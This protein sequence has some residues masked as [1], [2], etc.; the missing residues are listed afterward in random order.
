MVIACA[1]LADSLN[2]LAHGAAMGTAAMCGE[3]GAMQIAAPHLP[4][5][6]TATSRTIQHRWMLVPGSGSRWRGADAHRGLVEPSSALALEAEGQSATGGQLSARSSQL[7]D[8]YVFFDEKGELAPSPD[9]PATPACVD[10]GATISG[11]SA[12]DVSGDDIDYTLK[13][14][15]LTPDL[16]MTR[17]GLTFSGGYS[18]VE[19]ASV[20]AK[21]ARKNIGGRDREVAASIRLSQLRQAVEIGYGD[22]NFLGS[23]LALAPTLF[24]NRMSAKGFASGLGST[25]FAQGSYGATIQLSRKFE[26]Q[27]T[28]NAGYRLSAD[29]FRMRGKNRNCD[30]AL[31]GSPLCSALGNTTTSQ[32]SVSLVLDRRNRERYGTRGFRLRLAQ[33]AG[34]GGTAPFSRTRIGGEAHLGLGERLTLLV[35]VEG[36]YLAPMG[37]RDIPLFDR[38][39]AGDTSLRGFDLRG[40]GPKVRPAG[41]TAAQNIALGGRAYYAAR[42][43]LSASAGGFFEKLGVQPGIFIDAGSVFGARHTQLQPGEE[44]VGNS[45]RPRVAIG[46]GLAWKSPAGTLR[47]DL[48]KPVSRQSGDR[49]QLFGISFGAAL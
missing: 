42:I 30:V 43:E 8:G 26:N 18:S 32:L 10:D 19:G 25:P 13:N 3:P 15:D 22:G 6:S 7:N 29:S 28:L 20:G 34:I 45:A 31:F 16:L 1:H 48:A 21:L 37:K 41:A 44:L 4:I 27:L 38:F 14:Y 39:Y 49:S 47:F 35:D 11:E 23:S 5:Q 12:A 9:C 46:V 33:E 17:G 36:G 40:V 2:L 24:A